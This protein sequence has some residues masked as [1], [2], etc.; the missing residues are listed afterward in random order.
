MD[1]SPVKRMRPIGE[2]ALAPVPS[3]PRPASA[4]HSGRSTTSSNAQASDLQVTSTT[5]SA[6]AQARDLQATSATTSS[7]TQASDLQV[8]STTTAPTRRLAPCRPPRPQP[9]LTRRLA[10]CRSPRPQPG[11][12]P[13]GHLG[14]RGCA[15]ALR[16]RA[17]SPTEP[18]QRSHVDKSWPL[19]FNLIPPSQIQ[20]PHSQ[21]SRTKLTSLK[22]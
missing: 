11:S 2:S 19:R 15:H 3:R 9:A 21:R 14:H 10:T 16:T 18:Y 8:T 4:G 7:N 13:A 20:L 22:R 1:G 12:Q 5:T 6:H 17:G